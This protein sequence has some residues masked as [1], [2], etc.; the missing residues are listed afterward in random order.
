[1]RHTRSGRVPVI[2]CTNWG[3][4]KYIKGRVILDGYLQF[5]AV[6]Q[7]LIRTQTIATSGKD[8]SLV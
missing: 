3:P 4:R 7:T 1:M 5:L 2:Q 8:F 6:P